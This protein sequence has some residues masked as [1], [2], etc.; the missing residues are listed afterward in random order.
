MKDNG[1]WL[2]KILECIRP[3]NG[4]TVA[5]T[6]TTTGTGH[7]LA[8]EAARK[9]ATVLLLNRE[10]SRATDSLESLRKDVPT[11]VFEPF[12]CDLMSFASVRQ[13]ADE[14]KV[15]HPQIDVLCNN[16]GIMDQPDKAT[17]D[18]FD[19][20][21]QVNCHSHFLLTYLLFDCLEAAAEARGEAR[22]VSQTS[23]VRD[24]KGLKAK[25]LEKNSGNL[26][27]DGGKGKRYAQTKLGNIVF[28]SALSQRL[29][30][31]G[32]KVKAMT[33]HP[34]LSATNL[35]NNGGSAWIVD[36]L[37][38]MTSMVPADGAQG[39]VRCSLA[40]D[41]ANGDFIGPTGF[42]GM[43]GQVT[44]IPV[45]DHEQSPEQT[46]LY[47]TKSEEATGVIWKIG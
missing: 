8:A 18:G 36:K 4:K 17:E 45:K 28:S 38:K 40:D 16:A 15:K 35:F 29:E 31:A 22:V 26:G 5:I 11:G 37:I 27:G 39:I 19:V 47:W 1:K 23:F 9:G 2:P 6:G 44:K 12:T 3:Q 24:S 43:R 41:V 32:S 10:S 21:M 46:E 20:Q 42:L 7:V 13:A 34:G 33:A 14:I 25:Y 30:K